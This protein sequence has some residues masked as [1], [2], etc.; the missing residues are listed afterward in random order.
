M[1]ALCE[2][3]LTDVAVMVTVYAKSGV[4]GPFA[5]ATGAVYTVVI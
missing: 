2:L 3:L 5:G 4:M 1:L